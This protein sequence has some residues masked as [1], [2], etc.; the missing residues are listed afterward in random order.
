MGEPR[1]H[2]LRVAHGRALTVAALAASVAVAGCGGYIRHDELRRGVETLNSLAAEGALLA[3][4]IARDRT[5]HTFARVHAR[6]LADEVDHEVEK[7]HD[8]GAEGDLVRRK[9]EAVS[10]AQDISDALGDLQA[11]PGDE[12]TGRHVA[13]RLDHYASDAEDLAGAL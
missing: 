12:A 3:Q 1:L 11:A 13:T 7:L 10:L 8:A 6:E 9:A 5:R 2:T 4:D